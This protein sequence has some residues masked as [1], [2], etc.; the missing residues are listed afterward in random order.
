MAPQLVMCMPEPVLGLGRL[1]KNKEGK[2][3]SRKDKGSPGQQQWE[4]KTSA[5]NPNSGISASMDIDRTIAQ[6][7]AKRDYEKLA[8][9]FRHALEKYG[10][11]THTMYHQ[12]YSLLQRGHYPVKHS[13]LFQHDSRNDPLGAHHHEYITQA[14]SASERE[15]AFD[16][17]LK[18]L[19]HKIEQDQENNLNNDEVE[20]LRHLRLIFQYLVNVNAEEN[21]P[22]N[23]ALKMF[24]SNASE[25]DRKE[26]LNEFKQRAD[27]IHTLLDSLHIPL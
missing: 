20:Q 8:A 3:T 24:G 16:D 7:Q 15:V 10:G 17:I 27:Y 21:L 23:K 25:K 13:R 5:E 11:N 18:D 9:N 2:E 12:A 6:G 1:R 22:H 19:N 4:V 14:A 26:D